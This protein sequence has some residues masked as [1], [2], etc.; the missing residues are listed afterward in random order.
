MASAFSIPCNVHD[1][2]AFGGVFP[3]GAC[4]D[5]PPRIFGFGAFVQRTRGQ[6]SSDPI[7][8]W[9]L[10][11][12]HDAWCGPTKDFR[13]QASVCPIAAAGSYLVP[14]V[15]ELLEDRLYA[16]VFVPV[17]GHVGVLSQVVDRRHGAGAP[18][19]SGQAGVVDRD[20]PYRSARSRQRGHVTDCSWSA[21]SNPQNLRRGRHST[22]PG[23]R[24]RR[25]W[26]TGPG[27]TGLTGRPCRSCRPGSW[28]PTR[29]LRRRAG[30]RG[31][32]YLVSR[33]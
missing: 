33:A 31:R 1:R 25:G 15:G 5:D 32:P 24:V 16:G 9:A 20:A 13:V 11:G 3:R 23:S 12:Q 10:V 2:V 27:A 6:Q 21:S 26:R 29:S 4:C 28:P 30:G 7:V 22:S 17:D 18:G 14:C 19:G 8:G